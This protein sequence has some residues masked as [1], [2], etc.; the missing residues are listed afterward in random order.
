MSKVSFDWS[1]VI[2]S[3]N[4]NSFELCLRAL[5]RR[6]CSLSISCAVR[7]GVGL[8]LKKLSGA[9]YSGGRLRRAY[10][11]Y[12]SIDLM[13]PGG[14]HFILNSALFPL[15][16]SLFLF[17]RGFLSAYIS[18]CFSLF[19]PY[20]S[21]PLSLSLSASVCLSFYLYFA[22]SISHSYYVT[23][24]VSV[25]VS[26]SPF[27]CL[28]LSLS[29]RLAFSLSPSRSLSPSLISLSFSLAIYVSLSL[30]RPAYK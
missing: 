4:Q 18:V 25:S 6:S 10:L 7:P 5:L 3:T 8:G 24:S 2:N 29:L 20:L 15:F 14:V 11:R 28:S 21:L 9:I 30:S 26:P 22:L 23:A 17:I 16:R 13:T 27:F 1:I 12:N 19:L